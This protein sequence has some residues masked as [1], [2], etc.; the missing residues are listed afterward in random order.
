MV[1]R[2]RHKQK[3]T[4][5]QHSTNQTKN[6]THYYVPLL[7]RLS[8]NLPCL[9]NTSVKCTFK[10]TPAAVPDSWQA[11]LEASG[12][13]LPEAPYVSLTGLAVVVV[14]VVVAAAAAAAVVIAFPVDTPP[15]FQAAACVVHLRPTTCMLSV[16]VGVAAGKGGGG[17]G[18]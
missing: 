3:D 12:F 16:A 10:L 15:H 13:H 17:E 6:N 11:N 14:A 7:L 18:D 4:Q 8:Y 5:T 1:M 9:S 2:S